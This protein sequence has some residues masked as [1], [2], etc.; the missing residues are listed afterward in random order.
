MWSIDFVGIEADE[1]SVPGAREYVEEGILFAKGYF[2]HRK[3][4]NFIPGAAAFV[5]S[6]P[7][8]FRDESGE[9]GLMVKVTAFGEGKPAEQTNSMIQW[10]GPDKKLWRLENFVYFSRNDLF[11]WEYN[12]LVY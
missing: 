2:L 12:G 8:L 1:L 11:R 3:I 10:L 7:V 9:V 4:Y 5:L 6:N